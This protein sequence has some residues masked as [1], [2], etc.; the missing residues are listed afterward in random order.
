MGLSR[1]VGASVY[2]WDFQT[3]YSGAKAY[4]DGLN[5]YDIQNLKEEAGKEIVLPFAYP[6]PSL[7]FFRIFTGFSYPV[8]AQLWLFL[9]LVLVAALI[10]LWRRFFIPSTS[11]VL[12][13]L[14]LLLAFDAAIFWDLKAG[15]VAIIEQFLL[16]TGFVFL[17][18]RRPL[19]F[20]VFVILAAIFK[21][22]PIFFLCL[23][24]LSS[25]RNKWRYFVG[26]C[27]FFLM[28]MILC[29]IVSPDMV[30]SYV[31]SL[32]LIQERA[33]DY[34]YALLPFFQ[35]LIQTFGS[36]THLSI[37]ALTP[38]VLYMM[39]MIGILLTTAAA[40]RWSSR[41]KIV[42][43]PILSIMLVCIIYV[44]LVP[45]FKCYSYIILIAPACYVMMKYLSAKAYPFIF[46]LLIIPVRNPLPEAALI[47]QYRLY[48]LLYLT[49]ALWILCLKCIRLE[50]AAD[51]PNDP[52]RNSRQRDGASSG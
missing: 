29:Y 47:S 15:N 30:R 32:S 1:G 45:R 40:F 19:I 24:P 28:V 17:L 22:T 35:D 49:L 48:Y 14:M 12:F 9:K 13:S 5:P 10:V 31:S 6:P 16:W 7:W 20:C 23:L 36:L 25:L 52:H 50:V 26:A 8:A 46:L 37:P 34:N 43:D 42:L 27:T 33:P 21:V 41:N 38:L 51:A 2:E 3:Y 44:L 18:K 4:Q 39:A 11:A